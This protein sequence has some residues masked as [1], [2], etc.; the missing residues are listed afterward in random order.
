MQPLMIAVLHRQRGNVQLLLDARADPWQAIPI[1]SLCDHPCYRFGFLSRH[2]SVN[3]VQ[4]SVAQGL[5]DTVAD[6]L[7]QSQ[8]TQRRKKAEGPPQSSRDGTAMTEHATLLLGSIVQK[9]LLYFAPMETNIGR[10]L[11]TGSNWTG[12]P[13]TSW[14]DPSG[15]MARSG[16]PMPLKGSACS[17]HQQRSDHQPMRSTPY[18]SVL[19]VNSP[20]YPLPMLSEWLLGVAAGG[21]SALS[22]STVLSVLFCCFLSS[23]V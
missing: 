18:W 3:V 5:E 22:L 14:A 23:P 7:P 19:Y 21:L 13:P 8:D 6:L 2:E 16:R 15:N 9:Y 4:I 12:T 11:S 17:S 10:P 1:V 20:R